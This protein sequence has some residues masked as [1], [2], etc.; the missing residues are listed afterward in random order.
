MK[1]CK[2]LLT[3]QCKKLITIQCKIFLTGQCQKLLTVPGK[4]SLPN[5]VKKCLTFA[6]VSKSG[7]YDFLN[8]FDKCDKLS[9]PLPEGI[10]NYGIHEL[11]YGHAPGGNTRSSDYQLPDYADVFRQMTERKNMTLVFLWNRYVKRCEA[12]GL[13]AYRKQVMGLK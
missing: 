5:N 12:E 8:A 10:T 4:N 11:V 7:V 3:K 2:K 6:G 9:Y 1:E 13:K